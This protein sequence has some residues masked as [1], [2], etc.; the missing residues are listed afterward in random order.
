M[1]NDGHDLLEFLHSF[2]EPVEELPTLMDQVGV[3]RE[4]IAG[5]EIRCR[6]IAADLRLVGGRL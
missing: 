2:A 3:E 5:V 4:V 6:E 1:H